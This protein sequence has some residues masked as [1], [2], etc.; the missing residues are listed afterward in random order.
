M[1]SSLTGIIVSGIL[2]AGLPFVAIAKHWHIEAKDVRFEIPT[3]I[4]QKSSSENVDLWT[5]I[6]TLDLSELTGSDHIRQWDNVY[7]HMAKGPDL[8][9]YPFAITHEMPRVRR[10]GYAFSVKGTVTEREDKIIKLR[11]HFETFL[12]P[13]TARN[14][15]SNPGDADTTIEL[16]VNK[17]AVAR[18]VSVNIDG[19]RY[20]YRVLEKPVLRGLSQ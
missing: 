7:V 1:K 17:Q 14:L 12:P 9:A 18:L 16:A 10:D 6:N 19:V 15:I 13:R 3:N 2:L 8:I 4:S 20:P 11:Y 5:E